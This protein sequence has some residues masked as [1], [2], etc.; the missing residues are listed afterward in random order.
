[1]V[2]RNGGSFTTE[3]V[4]QS[5]RLK[6]AGKDAALGAMAHLQSLS[7]ATER[8]REYCGA[9]ALAHQSGHLGEVQGMIIS[10]LRITSSMG[11]HARKLDEC[12]A[13]E[14]AHAR[15]VAE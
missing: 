15:A 2:N 3:D 11:E 13:R 10:I 7:S 6:N 12:V 9:A 14:E 4:V 1:M 8:L 5:L